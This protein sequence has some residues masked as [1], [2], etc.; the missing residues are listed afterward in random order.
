[1]PIPTLC[2]LAWMTL[3]AQARGK[4]ADE[5]YGGFTALTPSTLTCWYRGVWD[6]LLKHFQLVVK[7]GPV[8]P[9]Q[10]PV[11]AARVCQCSGAM[12]ALM[13][14]CRCGAKHNA[15]AMRV[16]STWACNALQT[17]A[18]LWLRFHVKLQSIGVPAS[19][20]PLLD[21]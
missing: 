18:A 17:S 21:P 5:A 14:M 12:A 11:L 19:A 16:R 7:G 10:A 20:K 15:S 2:F 8:T 13:S 1:M 6:A 3:A 4:A 9:D